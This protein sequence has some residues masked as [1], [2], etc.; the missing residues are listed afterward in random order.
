MLVYYHS[1]RFAA[2]VVSGLMKIELFRLVAND[3][4]NLHEKQ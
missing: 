1:W 4:P 2:A 3:M